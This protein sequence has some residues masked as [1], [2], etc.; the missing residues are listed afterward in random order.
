ME[1]LSSRHIISRNLLVLVSSFI[2]SFLEP[3]VLEDSKR[4]NVV[5]ECYTLSHERAIR[6]FDYT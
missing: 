4:A 1:D 3:D 5:V 6:A 2:S